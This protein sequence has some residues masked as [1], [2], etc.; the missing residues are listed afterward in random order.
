MF[1]ID[2][3]APLVPVIFTPPPGP[4][5]YS[6]GEVVLADYRCFDSGS[7]IASCNGTVAP[8]GR[9]TANGAAVPTNRLGTNTLTV[10]GTDLLGRQG[11]AATRAY[12][13]APVFSGFFPPVDNPPGINVVS[14]GQSIPVKFGIGGDAGLN[15]FAAGYP[16]STKI[17]CDNTAPLDDI[18]QTTTASSGLS[19]SGGQYLYVWKTDKAWRGTC[20]Q[21]T[22]RF[23][24]G[25]EKTALFKFK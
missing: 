5:T 18:E 3:S 2:T 24:D 13:V 20:R 8:E 6:F 9:P 1:V 12:I 25:T 16:Q 14:G 10:R 4:V 22:L 21:L 7:G 19:F 15:I 23:A 17:A 11:P